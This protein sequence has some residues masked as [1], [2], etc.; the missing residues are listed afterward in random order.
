MSSIAPETVII[1][2]PDGRNLDSVSDLLKIRSVVTTVIDTVALT[3]QTITVADLTVGTLNG[4]PI[5]G[6]F[7]FT[8]TAQTLSN[9]SLDDTTT[10]FVDS[11]DP[12]IAARVDA[13][14]TAGTTAVL[15]FTQTGD[16]V[17]TL[18]GPAAS[19][20]TT[21]GAQT[22]NGTKTFASLAVATINEAAVDA[23][24]TI[25]GV[26]VR[27]AVRAAV[28]ETI[29]EVTPIGP[30]AKVTLALCPRGTGALQAE[31]ATNAVAGGAL[32]GIFA[33]DFQR[34][35]TAATAVA[36][37]PSSVIAGGS[38]NRT[39]TSATLAVIGGGSGNTTAA[40]NSFV[41]GGRNNV[42]SAAASYGSIVGGDGNAVSGPNSFIGGG[43]AGQATGTDSAIT[44]GVNCVASGN[45]AYISHGTNCQATSTNSYAFGQYARSLH[46]NSTVMRGRGSVA[47]FDSTAQNQ[48]S[49]DYELYRWIGGVMSW[50]E[51]LSQHSD[52]VVSTV[53]AAS[54]GLY[55]ITTETNTVNIF[56]MNITGVIPGGDIFHRRL[57][58]HT[59]NLAGGLQLR[60]EFDSYT[61]ADPGVPGAAVTPVVVLGNQF[62]VQVTGTAG[63][64]MVWRG[65]LMQRTSPF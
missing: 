8:D 29:A 37:G 57:S 39:L 41:G 17:Y 42:I 53:G 4:Q 20:V 46:A 58:I 18:G 24:V 10:R 40:I 12:T 63:F 9:K 59:K 28:A 25:D 22:I 2:A 30:I 21:E 6:A 65:D 13:A 36:Q 49:A 34:Q 52:G 51:R 16:T 64:T 50:N 31:V 61:L 35:R 1:T 15:R 14:G 33:V 54:T 32:R 3:A 27:A 11:T 5:A 56:T 19:I 45:G 26:L 7:V 38:N 55:A 48:L 62:V 23:G 47:N 44:T 60:D 43:T